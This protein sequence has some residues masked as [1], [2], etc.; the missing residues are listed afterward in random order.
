MKTSAKCAGNVSPSAREAQL[1][2]SISHHKKQLKYQQNLLH[3]RFKEQNM[4][5]FK[6]GGIHP[7]DNKLAKNSSVE[8][9]PIPSQV[10][11]F[12]TQHLGAPATPIVAKG[13][14]VKVGQLI[15]K[16]EA[17]ISANIHSP[18]SGTVNKI[19]MVADIS[20]Y[21]KQAVVIDVEGDEWCE[22]I[23]TTPELKTEIT[24]DK[25]AI[26]NRMKD[27]GIVGLGGACF[28]T[29][30]KYMLRPEQ[31]VDFLL[32]NAAECEPYITTDYR[33]LLEK[34]DECLVGIQA[35]LIASDAPIACIGIENNKKDAI[36]I[37]T[38]K[39]KK[40][41]QIKVVELKTKYPQGAEKQLI[42]AITKREVPNGKL[43]IDVGCI[44]NNFTTTYAV[45][46]AVQKNKPIVEIFTTVS[47]KMLENRKNFR[48]RI[49]TPIDSIM[50]SVGIPENT[51]KF[52]SGGPMM[53]KAIT[54]LNSFAVKG[55][56]SILFMDM[57]EAKRHTSSDCIRCGKCV[58]ACPM[59]LQPY[60][61]QILSELERYED[62]EQFGIMNCMECGCCQFGCPAFR[63][64]LDYVRVGKNKTGLMIRNRQK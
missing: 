12:L 54:N 58:A 37:L 9:F 51:G 60:K 23:D 25:Q 4:K 38:D 10:T 22:N 1:L 31:K 18:V 57:S 17:F 29:H 6:I 24:L 50:K 19:D 55:M 47:G 32:I 41:P 43:P 52:I 45:Y 5:T 13:D 63:P 3:Y 64:I 26:I 35:L 21:K 53:G 15:G 11:V 48:V 20:G 8:S 42:K 27:C 49:G 44:V 7:E 14:K 40:Y 62:C 39:A 34:A 46:E 61:L 16:A 36:A 28:P 33:L 59:G 30:V 56:S 2:R